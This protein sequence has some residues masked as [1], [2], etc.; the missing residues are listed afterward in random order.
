MMKVSVVIPARNEERHIAN[1]IKKVSSCNLVSEVLVVNNNSKDNT[2]QIALENGANVVTCRKI[3]KGYAME[4]GISKASG[5]VILFVDAD[6]DNYDEDIVEKML[7]PL[8]KNKCDFVKSTFK[9]VGGRVTRLVAKP[10]LELTFPEL[11][12]FGQP[13]SGIIA[14]KKEVFQKIVLE[15]DYGVDIGILIDLYNLGV[16]MREVNI[17]KIENDS[18]D[19]INLIEMS[20]Q[21]TKAIIKRKLVNE[22][23]EK[24]F[25]TL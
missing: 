7:T 15:K 4:L 5:D 20:R 10:L 23:E 22:K 18:Q 25:V 11:C 2:K 13:L 19:W 24:E 14:G 21:V 16:S 8:I 9:R 12:K 3:G 6:I 1:V 17:G